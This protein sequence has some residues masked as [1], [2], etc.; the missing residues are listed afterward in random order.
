MAEFV[1]GWFECGLLD[2][3]FWAKKEIHLLFGDESGL[4]PSVKYMDSQI[5][6]YHWKNWTHMF[7]ISYWQACDLSVHPC[8]F[9]VLWNMH[10]LTSSHYTPKLYSITRVYHGYSDTH[11]DNVAVSTGVGMVSQNL[12]CVER[13]SLKYHTQQNTNN[14]YYCV[15]VVK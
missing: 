1:T 14:V 6:R 13:G 3:T 15:V 7:N 9:H 2:V 5:H 4:V 10:V 8:G 11:S 12:L